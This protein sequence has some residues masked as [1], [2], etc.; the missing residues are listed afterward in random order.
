ML[1]NDPQV[2]LKSVI[3]VA[4]LQLW[5]AWLSKDK[6]WLALGFQKPAK[7]QH[8]WPVIYLVANVNFNWNLYSVIDKATTT[9][10]IRLNIV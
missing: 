4:S 6:I 8:H 7:S 1:M 9:T 2:H 5:G 10:K 3:K